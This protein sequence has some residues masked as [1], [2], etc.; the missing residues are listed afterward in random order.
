MKLAGCGAKAGL[1]AAAAAVLLL[2]AGPA[3]AADTGRWDL[4]NQYSGDL[5]GVWAH[6]SLWQTPDRRYHLNGEVKDTLGDGKGAALRIDAYYNDGGHRPEVVMNMLGSGKVVTFDF[7]FAS[8]VDFFVLKE[9]FLVRNSSGAIVM[10]DC[11]D[12]GRI[13]FM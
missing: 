10:G 6:G 1:G 7:N 13:Y 12:P 5:K 4:T 2:G 9:C 8:N 11:A 3:H